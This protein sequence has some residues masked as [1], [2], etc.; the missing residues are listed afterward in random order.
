MSLHRR[1]LNLCFYDAA[2]AYL[3][4]FADRCM[5]GDRG[6]AQA[7]TG[8]GSLLTTAG[9]VAKDLVRKH[10]KDSPKVSRSLLARR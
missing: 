3:V 9:L 6:D 7:P 1:Q 5:I 4:P 8:V 2:L 10:G